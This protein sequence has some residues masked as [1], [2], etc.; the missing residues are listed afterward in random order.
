MP[1]LS[2][3][4][5]EAAG[6]VRWTIQLATW[7]Y[8]PLSL[9]KQYFFFCLISSRT[10]WYFFLKGNYSSVEMKTFNIHIPFVPRKW[11][12]LETW[13]CKTVSCVRTEIM[14]LSSSTFYWLSTSI[15]SICMMIYSSK[16]INI[17][18]IRKIILFLYY[19]RETQW[20]G[21]VICKKC[22][23]LV[24]HTKARRSLRRSEQIKLAKRKKGSS[25][26]ENKTLI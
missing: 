15:L 1:F 9:E 2:S 22:L 12:H 3:S 23:Q 24:S 11:Q 17:D 4:A 18:P 14:L 13:V 20:E 10:R 21:C 8:G 19:Q 16:I 7:S 6:L 26:S 25:M 5:N